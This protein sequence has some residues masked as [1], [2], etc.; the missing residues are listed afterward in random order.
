MRHS[1]HSGLAELP[2][3]ER[4]AAPLDRS[5]L[6]AFPFVDVSLARLCHQLVRMSVILRT[7]RESTEF[8][9]AGPT[10]LRRPPVYGKTPERVIIVDWI[11][12]ACN[13]E[14]GGSNSVLIDESRALE[15]PQ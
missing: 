4:L 15:K 6:G 10:Q 2:D 14:M 11:F 5:D 9:S 12:L 7:R 3:R 8:Q 1:R 13:A